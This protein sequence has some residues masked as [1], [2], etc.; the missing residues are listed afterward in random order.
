MAATS[1]VVVTWQCAGELAGL[2]R[3]MTAQLP[4]EAVQ[5]VVIDNASDDDPEAAAAT[6]PGETTFRRLPSNAGYG[7]AANVGVTL[8]SH[9]ATVLINPD[10]RLLDPGL[11]AL[12][13]E[14]LRLNALVGPRVLR[15]DGSLEPSASGPPVGAW[16]WVMAVLPGPVLPRAARRMTAP[17]RLA[18]ATRVAWLSASCVAAPTGLLRRL[19][20]FDPQLELYAEDL[21][22][23]LRAEAA[24]IERWFRPDLC[25]VSH[26]GQASS[27]R[28]YADAGAAVAARNRRAVIRRA[29]GETRERRGWRAHRLG[30]GL[31]LAV[32]RLLRRPADDVRVPL[33]GTAAAPVAA[34]L[35]PFHGETE[36]P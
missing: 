36:S 16:P 2:I 8:A 26:A 12:A 17:W 22:L 20:P 23:C 18:D 11:P 7:A 30:L 24:G 14:A 33:A 3:S 4:A 27:S 5:L 29:Y 19:G 13:R 1:V 28:R 31:R 9:D 25:S 21:D 6:W 10:A 15:G 34:A 32:K 35:E